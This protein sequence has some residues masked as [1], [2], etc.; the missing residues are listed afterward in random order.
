[1]LRTNL[2]VNTMYENLQRR[3][4]MQAL[5][6]IVPISGTGATMDMLAGIGHTPNGYETVVS[7]LDMYCTNVLMYHMMVLLARPTKVRC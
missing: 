7:C 6:I 4:L 1:M 5:L 2:D 3:Q